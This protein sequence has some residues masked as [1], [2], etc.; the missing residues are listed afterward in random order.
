MS[1]YKKSGDDYLFSPAAVLVL[2]SDA[3]HSRDTDLSGKIRGKLIVE[4]VMSAARAAKFE[5]ADILET[6]L[7]SGAPGAKLL[8]LCRAL[9]ARIG[10]EAFAAALHRAGLNVQLLGGAS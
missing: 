9:T 1:D 8:P 6:M 10:G 4:E 2:A 3:I 5:Q 7:L